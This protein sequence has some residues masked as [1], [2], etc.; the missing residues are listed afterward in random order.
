MSQNRADPAECLTR[1][2]AP[3]LPAPVVLALRAGTSLALQTT[4]C[5]GGADQRVQDNDRGELAGRERV[6]TGLAA[7]VVI[8]PHHS[9]PRTRLHPVLYRPIPVRPAACTHSPQ[10]VSSRYPSGALPRCV[11]P[12][13]QAATRSTDPGARQTRETSPTKREAKAR[14][15]VKAIAV[16]RG[17]LRTAGHARLL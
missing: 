13:A 9:R 15:S 14:K 2:L 16:H 4:S 5:A 10:R 8:Q 1:M 7:G 12:D 11:A 3:A 17:N 6:A